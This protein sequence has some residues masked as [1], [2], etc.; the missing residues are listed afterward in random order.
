VVTHLGLELLPL[1]DAVVEEARHVDLHG[2]GLVAQV[3]QVL[4]RRTLRAH[5]GRG[6][7][8]SHALARVI[9]SD[10]S[11]LFVQVL[12]RRTLRAH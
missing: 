4:V 8:G 7:G 5:E 11:V 3:L 6:G 9:Q 2:D 12:V 1:A 10:E